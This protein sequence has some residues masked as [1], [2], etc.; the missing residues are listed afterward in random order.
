M[1]DDNHFQRQ[2]GRPAG[3]VLNFE[4]PPGSSNFP[5]VY[6]VEF[7][8]TRVLIGRCPRRRAKSG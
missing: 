3:V 7:D 2:G 8:A 4:H 6:F 5:D 1:G